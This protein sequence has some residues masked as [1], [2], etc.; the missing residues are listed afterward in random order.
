[1]ASTSVEITGIEFKTADEAIQ[2]AD[3]GGGHAISVWGR[4]L[5]VKKAEADRIAARGVEFAY[6]HVHEM[7]DGSERIVTV[8]IN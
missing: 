1:M 2:H 8:P 4:Y 6:L 7:P 5:V 3:A